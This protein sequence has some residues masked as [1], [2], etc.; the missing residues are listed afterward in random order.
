LRKATPAAL[1]EEVPSSFRSGFGT[2]LVP[3]WYSFEDTNAGA[4]LWF[5]RLKQIDLDGTVSFSETLAVE[6]LPTKPAVGSTELSFL[7]NYPNPFNPSTTI[8]YTVGGVR[9][10]ASGVSNVRLAIY[11]LL[12]REVAVLVNE[13]QPAGR[14]EVTFDGGRLAS[15]TYLYRIVA[16]RFVQVRR[17]VLVR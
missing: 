12:G 10:Q 7:Q 14:Y 8:E 15:G 6:A 9:S 11:D 2:S 1:F 5:Y 16:G 3:H 4:G 17:M 13:K